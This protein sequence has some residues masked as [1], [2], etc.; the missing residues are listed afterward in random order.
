MD[1][2][3]IGLSSFNYLKHFPVDYV[4]IDGS[5]IR[6]LKDSDIDRAI[7]ESIHAIAGKIGAQTVAEFV[8]DAEL[9]TLVREI[10]IDY[11]QGYGIGKPLPLDEALKQL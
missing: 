1:D 9:L 7:V 11:A 8:E 4:K 6:K 10:G 5:F 3:G 2:F